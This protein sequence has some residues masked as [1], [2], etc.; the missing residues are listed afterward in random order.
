M[1][2][3]DTRGHSPR[4]CH[5]TSIHTHT[6]ALF[7]AIGQVPTYHVMYLIL[8]PLKRHYLLN[9]TLAPHANTLL[10]NLLDC[11]FWYLSLY[12]SSTFLCCCFFAFNFRYYRLIH[13]DVG[14]RIS[15]S[16]TTDPVH[17]ARLLSLHSPML[18]KSAFNVKLL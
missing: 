6:E 18:V 9:A 2:P 15:L 8:W 4:M 5:R 14:I 11:F 7:Y 3:E 13:K 16:Y 1:L 12:F 17:A 10:P